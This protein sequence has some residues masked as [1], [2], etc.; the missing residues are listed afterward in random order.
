MGGTDNC[1]VFGNY[2]DGRQMQ[3]EEALDALI[4]TRAGTIISCVP[5]RLAFFENDDERVILHRC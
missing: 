3:L 4:G 5:G 2:I 1:W